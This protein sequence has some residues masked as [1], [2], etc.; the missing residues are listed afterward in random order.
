MP[1][2]AG[3]NMGVAAVSLVALLGLLALIATDTAGGLDGWLHLLYVAPAAALGG[4]GLVHLRA[5]LAT[6][7]R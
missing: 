2:R 6:R 1:A 4:A 3:N 5:A 7:R